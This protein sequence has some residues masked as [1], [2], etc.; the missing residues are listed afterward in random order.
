MSRTAAQ[1]SAD[2]ARARRARL[3]NPEKYR[4]HAAKFRANLTPEQKALRAAYLK[5]WRQKN[6]KRIKR[7]EAA[8]RKVR[9]EKG[10]QRYQADP[11]KRLAEHKAWRTRN[12]NYR[13]E[14]YHRNHE[15]YVADGPMSARSRR[16]RRLL[17]R[18]AATMAAGR[19]AL[20]TQET[21]K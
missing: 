18:F 16:T 19:R 11:A 17:K 12:P 4:A 6:A 9:A 1:R 15:R 7:A 2:A 3:A 13:R 10:R 21:V 14:H 5:A 8:Y 20:S